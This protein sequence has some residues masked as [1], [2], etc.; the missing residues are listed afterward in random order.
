M[1]YA[2]E[3]LSLDAPETALAQTKRWTGEVKLKG[4]VQFELFAWKEGEVEVR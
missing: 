4:D 2:E 1:I 3:L